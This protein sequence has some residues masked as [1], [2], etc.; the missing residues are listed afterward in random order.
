MD[1]FVGRPL[2]DM[3]LSIPRVSSTV[4]VAAAFVRVALILGVAGSDETAR[5]AETFDHSAW[6]RLLERYVDGDGRVAYRDLAANDSAALDRYLAALAAARPAELSRAEK[7]AFWLNAYNAVV[8]KAVLDG[9]SAESVF[10]RYRMFYGYERTVAGEPRTPDE[11]ENEII[12]PS[13]E[14]RIH[15]ALVCASSSCPRLRRQAWVGETLD[16]DLDEEA[17]RF[18]G[19]PVRNRIRVGAPEIGLSKI[20]EWYRSDFGGSD[21][22]VREFVTRY[23]GEAERADLEQRRPPIE[24]L[25]YD[26]SMNVQP[27]QRPD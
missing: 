8:V 4:R 13:G 22:S 3:G 9:R 26:W 21:D 19:D 5:A 7:I 25:E 23:V 27:G 12:R 17:R 15:F 14:K 10:G 2:L 11:I 18:L 1:A 16:R 6:T 20:F 24:F